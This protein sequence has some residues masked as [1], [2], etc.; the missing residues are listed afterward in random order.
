MKCKFEKEVTMKLQV[1][2]LMLFSV[3]LFACGDKTDNQA[4]T[5]PAWA[6]FISH[7]QSI[8]DESASGQLAT[9]AGALAAETDT[10]PTPEPTPE[11]PDLRKSKTYCKKLQNSYISAL[12]FLWKGEELSRVK[13][14]VL[15]KPK[16]V[17]QVNKFAADLVSHLASRAVQ[18]PDAT[19][20]EKLNA[21]IQSVQTA[22]T[23]YYA[24]IQTKDLSGVLDAF[25]ELKTNFEPLARELIELQ[26]GAATL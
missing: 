8:T 2:V 11:V 7:P 24:V 3:L 12:R 16:T 15:F 6:Q 17:K 23:K 4:P 10:T 19:Q 13:P 9:D 1:T 20:R 5:N 14:E 26:C 21:L 25:T 22:L 18:I